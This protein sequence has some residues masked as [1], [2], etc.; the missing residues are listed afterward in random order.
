M[1]TVLLRLWVGRV[2]QRMA[3]QK[4]EKSSL[5]QRALQR[6]S[7]R[8]Q[9]KKYDLVI[10][11]KDVV[12]DINEDATKDS[13]VEA[14]QTPSSCPPTPY[15]S[16]RQ[17]PSSSSQYNPEYEEDGG[18]VIAPSKAVLGRDREM[19]G[20]KEIGV[21]RAQSMTVL[22]MAS[23]GRTITIPS[24]QLMQMN[25]YQKRVQVSMEKL[26]VP[27]WFKSS[28]PSPET[29]TPRTP[30]WKPSGKDPLS[31]TSSGWRRHLSHHTPPSTASTL[32]R[33]STP[34]SSQRYRSRLGSLAASSRSPS[35]SSMNS[36]MSSTCPSPSKPLYLGWRSQERLDTDL[37]YQSSPASRLAR[38]VLHPAKQQTKVAASK[39]AADNSGDKDD[40]ENVKSD[41]MNITEAILNYCNTS[42]HDKSSIDNDS[43]IKDNNSDEDK[44]EK[45]DDSGIDRSDDYRQEIVNESC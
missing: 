45:D 21:V 4:K 30:R 35:I 17:S 10:E 34:L 19:Q 27:T 23:P 8:T 2:A 37:N 40:V 11:K 6:L 3:M 39:G 31:S 22:D 5:F 14:V 29:S 13:E 36:S 25:Q 41:I 9:K 33:N 44:D 15:C 20:E 18:E 42:S 16:W 26:N 7:F 38:S 24:N 12:N 43:P 32:E 28:N 1:G